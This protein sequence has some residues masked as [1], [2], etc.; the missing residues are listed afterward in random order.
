M[1][2][3]V[4]LVTLEFGRSVLKGSVVLQTYTSCCSDSN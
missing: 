3:S 1:E 2:V 4:L